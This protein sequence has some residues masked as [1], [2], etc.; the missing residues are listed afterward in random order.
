MEWRG[1][2]CWN[3]RLAVVKEEREVFVGSR[4][5]VN[6]SSGSHGNEIFCQKFGKLY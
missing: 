1:V 3:K 6:E 2:Q 4:V 5:G